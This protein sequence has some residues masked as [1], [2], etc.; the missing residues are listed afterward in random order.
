MDRR[1]AIGIIGS[2]VCA[3]P[4]AGV[5]P[6]RQQCAPWTLVDEFREELAS[7]I[8]EG[9]LRSVPWICRGVPPSSRRFCDSE[10][11]KCHSMI[12]SFDMSSVFSAA[13]FRDAADSFKRD[14]L[15]QCK[16][17]IYAE[18]NMV[19]QNV[20]Q[21]FPIRRVH[22]ESFTTDRQGWSLGELTHLYPMFSTEHVTAIFTKSGHRLETLHCE[23]YMC[24]ESDSLSIKCF[25]PFLLSECGWSSSDGR[26][27]GVDEMVCRVAYS[28][29]LRIPSRIVDRMVL[30]TWHP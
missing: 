24:A 18:T 14:M 19:I 2:I 30:S 22:Y 9:D 1:S 29:D 10:F 13:S 11:V 28:F 15:R 5:I 3:I 23:E 21:S 20:L 26:L 17:R 25:G 4:S 8:A 16:K 6:R 27:V 7:A 12:M